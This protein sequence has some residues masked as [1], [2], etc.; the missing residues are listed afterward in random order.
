MLQTA[1]TIQIKY[2]T[3]FLIE[4]FNC[5]A[6]VEGRRNCVSQDIIDSMDDETKFPVQKFYINDN[7]VKTQ[8]V[9]NASGDTI[10][11]DL[12]LSEWETMPHKDIKT[13]K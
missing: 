12:S 9:L 10:A 2:F 11:F 5:Q 7:H 3:K 1:H 8:F 4:Q 6:I 13:G